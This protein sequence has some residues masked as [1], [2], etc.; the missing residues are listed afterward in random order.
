MRKDS[1]L[2]PQKNN[3]KILDKTLDNPN[4]WDYNNIKVQDF[5]TKSPFLSAGA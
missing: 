3:I 1:F 4:V 5:L 2:L